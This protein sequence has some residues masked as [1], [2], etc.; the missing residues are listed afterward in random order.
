MTECQTITVDLDSVY[1]AEWGRK[2]PTE[3][4]RPTLDWSRADCAGAGVTISTSTWTVHPDDADGN[5][6]LTAFS[7]QGL[8]T[9]CAASA[10]VDGMSYRM[11]NQVTFSD[12]RVLEATV[13]Q[14]VFLTRAMAA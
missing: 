9:S 7:V 8:E 10:G 5:F 2:T 4:R 14:P 1:P 6:T 11:V 12:G 3:T 13:V